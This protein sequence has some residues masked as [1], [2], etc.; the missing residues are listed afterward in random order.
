MTANE[1]RA[2]QRYLL[3]M[4]VTSQPYLIMKKYTHRN[5]DPKSVVL[6]SLD[7]GRILTRIWNG[8]SSGHVILFSTP[9]QVPAAFPRHPRG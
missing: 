1:I 7:G 8:L 6:F 4:C 9:F 5:Y 2:F 3:R